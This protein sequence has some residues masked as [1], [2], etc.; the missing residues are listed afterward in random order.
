MLKKIEDKLGISQEAVLVLFFGAVL[1]LI[2]AFIPAA[3]A[4]VGAAVTLLAPIWI[5]IALFAVFWKFWMEY[6]RAKYIAEQD[7]VL[8]EIRLPRDVHKS[9][10]AMETVFSNLHFG[11]GE[12]TFIDKYIKGK[13]RPWWSFEIASI[14]GN[15]HFFVWTR[16]AFRNAVQSAIY[17]QYPDAEVVEVPD[18]TR[19]LGNETYEIWGADLKLSNKEIGES[20][21]IKTYMDYGLDKNPKEEEK[22]DPLASVLEFIGSLTGNEQIWIQII[23][24]QTKGDWDKRAKAKLD[25]I[26]KE[27]FGDLG[28][29]V[30]GMPIKMDMI[31]DTMK[32]RMEAINRK[33]NKNGFDTGIRM[34]YMAR[35]GH[36][37]PNNISAMLGSFKQFNANNLNGF[38]PT[39]YLAALDFPWQK[40]FGRQERARRAVIDAYR[41]RAWFHAPYKTDSYVLNTEELATLYHLPSSIV[42][43]PTV[44]RIP[45]RRQ[46]PPANL[47]R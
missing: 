7:M 10:L 27:A 40:W 1:V 47:P 11:P 23:I 12:S 5:P 31:T 28:I 26:R 18:Y 13:V 43:T 19:M 42:Q 25:E 16:A 44:S 14:G 41:R 35:E 39:R 22:V 9:P 21:P 38:A 36:F 45:S 15:I 8:L 30:G 37:D 33:I 6:I 4:R 3:P 24:Q 34:I 29:G 2:G 17:A 46:E 32:Q 20:L